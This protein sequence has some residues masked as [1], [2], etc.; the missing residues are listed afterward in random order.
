LDGATNILRAF[1]ESDSPPR[2]SSIARREVS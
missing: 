2:Y 1:H